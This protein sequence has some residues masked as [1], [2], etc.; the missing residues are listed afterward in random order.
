M[1]KT[2]IMKH[3][4]IAQYEGLTPNYLSLKPYY[5]EEAHK[6]WIMYQDP[7]KGVFLAKNENRIYN[8]DE[9]TSLIAPTVKKT[10]P[11]SL[12]DNQTNRP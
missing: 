11:M 10:S 2:T 4:K 3:S 6:R 7:A 8:K 12:V 5:P 1:A 9:R